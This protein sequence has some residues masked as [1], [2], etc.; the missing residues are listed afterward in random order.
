[1]TDSSSPDY[2]LRLK[3]LEEKVRTGKRSAEA[4]RRATEARRGE[5]G[6]RP[7]MKAARRKRDNVN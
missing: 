5:I 3:Q 4:G 7:K 1:M 6:S 2:K